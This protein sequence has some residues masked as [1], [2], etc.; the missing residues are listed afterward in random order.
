MINSFFQSE[1][2]QPHVGRA[3]AI[4]KAH[5]EVRE[6]MVRNPYTAVIAFSIVLL[7]TGIVF[8]RKLGNCWNRF[9]TPVLSY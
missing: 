2:D 3:R 9:Q 7:Q 1:L 5:P 4:I 8:A 6:L